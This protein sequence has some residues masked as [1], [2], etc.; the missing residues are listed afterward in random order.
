MENISKEPEDSCIYRRLFMDYHYGLNK[1]YTSAEIEKAKASPSFEREYC[2][3]FSGRQGN[4]ISQLKIQTAI[5]T[6]E[7]LKD[8]QPNLYNIFSLGVDPAFG[9][10]AFGLVLTEHLKE[11]DK[12]IVRYAE[13]FENHPD[14]QDMINL[15]FID[16]IIIYGYLLMLQQE[17]LSHH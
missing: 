16:S 14:P 6:G 3:K 8:I 1:I 13:Q 5:D 10:S 4:L 11:E 9:S 17:D 2:L 12:I 15:T 7:R